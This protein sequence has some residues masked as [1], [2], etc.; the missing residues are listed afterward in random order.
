MIALLLTVAFISQVSV[1]LH[2]RMIRIKP[3]IE[4]TFN[5]V[6]LGSPSVC[7]FLGSQGRVKVTDLSRAK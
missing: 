3:V 4:V 2:V 1:Y 5:W 7:W 6:L